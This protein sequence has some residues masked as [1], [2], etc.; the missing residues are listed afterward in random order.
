MKRT[1]AVLSLVGCAFAAAVSALSVGCTVDAPLDTTCED[2][3]S[4]F[5]GICGTVNQQYLGATT[6]DRR[7]SCLT[8]CRVLRT[9]GE[10][11]TGNT[12]A[13][14]N[15]SLS[16]AGETKATEGELKKTLCFNAGPIGGAVNSASA[17]CGAA[18]DGKASTCDNFCFLHTAR[19]TGQDAVPWPGGIGQANCTSFCNAELK[20]A[21]Q[22]A[23]KDFAAIS[24]PSGTDGI[25]SD[26]IK[27][28]NTGACRVYHLATSLQSI[29]GSASEHCSH[30]AEVSVKCR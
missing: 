2:Y 17:V 12:I 4:N 1:F 8:S 7:A 29:A 16:A 19:C 25:D 5:Q 15:S 11:K 21:D 30:S 20:K 3:C 6:S 24:T 9:N 26:A 27:T 23:F 22:G 18:G 28:G 13:C 14:R 10:S